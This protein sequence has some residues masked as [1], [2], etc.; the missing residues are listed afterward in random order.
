[1]GMFETKRFLVFTGG[2]YYADGGWNDFAGSFDDLDSAVANAQKNID[3][4]SHDWWQVVDLSV[5]VV[6][7]SHGAPYWA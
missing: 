7:A 4:K 2:T 5:C 6:V 1:M 3:T